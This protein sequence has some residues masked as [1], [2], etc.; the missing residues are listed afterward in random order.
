MKSPEPV[1]DRET[2]RT[3]LEEGRSVLLLDVRPTAE[4]SEW[5]IPG[6]LHIDAYDRLKMGDPS[7]LATLDV[8]TDTPVVTICGAGRTSLIA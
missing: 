5:A 1:I 7:A 3:W 6:S 8:P 2:L 4:R